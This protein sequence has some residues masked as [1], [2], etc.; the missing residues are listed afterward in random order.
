MKKPHH[1][2]KDHFL[3]QIM[4]LK[5]PQQALKYKPGRTVR[6]RPRIRWR[7][8]IHLQRQEEA[9]KPKPAVVQKK[10]GGGG[11]KYFLS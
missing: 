6:G 10:R 2:I 5:L 3:F 4:F 8:Q 7:D 1:H 11:G 9:Q